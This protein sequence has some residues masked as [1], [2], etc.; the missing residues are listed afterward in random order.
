MDYEWF[1]FKLD[2]VY[3][4]LDRLEAMIPK[5]GSASSVT[6]HE[7]KGDDMATKRDEQAADYRAEAIERV[8]PAGRVTLEVTYDPQDKGQPKIWRWSTTFTCEGESVRVVEEDREAADRVSREEGYRVLLFEVIA[9]RN[10]RDTAIRERDDAA[11]NRDRLHGELGDCLQKLTAAQT[12][13]MELRWAMQKGSADAYNVSAARI[14]RDTAIKRAEAAEARVA[15]LEAEQIGLRRDVMAAEKEADSLREQLESAADR[16]AAAETALGSAPAAGGGAAL[17]RIA[18]AFG[19]KPDDDDDLV[20]AARLLV[21]ERDEAIKRA[22]AA[23]AA[24]AASGADSS[25]SWTRDMVDGVLALEHMLYVFQDDQRPAVQSRLDKLRRLVEVVGHRAP[26]AS[27]GGGLKP[28][29]WGVV[30]KLIDAAEGV[31]DFAGQPLFRDLKRYRS[32][33]DKLGVAIAAAEKMLLD[34][35]PAVSASG[36]GEGEG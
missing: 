35:L 5:T 22:E 19:C 31:R 9:A 13:A 32:E 30:R 7:N 11:R 23:E 10:E 36:G 28:H 12:E 8:A 2:E 33:V 17:A 14:E 25:E 24:P 20:E 3:E 15:E 26:A 18:A 4:A 6:E 34:P 29:Q 27:G 16:A 1:K 21:R